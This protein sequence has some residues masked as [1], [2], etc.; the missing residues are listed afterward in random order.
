MALTSS[1]FIKLYSAVDSAWG[2]QSTLRVVNYFIPRDGLPPHRGA[3]VTLGVKLRSTAV[4]YSTFS[5]AEKEFDVSGS[6]DAQI[7][8]GHARSNIVLLNQLLGG[9]LIHTRSANAYGE[10]GRTCK[11]DVRQL[12]DGALIIRGEKVPLRN[13]GGVGFVV[14]P[15]V[16]H[17][18]VSHEFLSPPLAILQLRPLHWKTITIINGCFL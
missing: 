12:S 17:L 13:D 18:V 7:R 6:P 16:V 2:G 3:G 14:H 1:R 4:I 5:K 9:S 15:S 11:T 10:C 8:V